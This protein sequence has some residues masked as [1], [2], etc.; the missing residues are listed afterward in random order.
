M[1][2][3]TDRYELDGLDEEQRRAVTHG[4]GPLLVMAGPGSGKTRVLTNRV[5]HLIGEGAKP[6]EILCLTFTEKAAAEMLGRLGRRFD[7]SNMDVCTFHAFAKKM[8]GENDLETGLNVSRG[9]I[10]R[11]MARA[12]AMGHIDEF[13][14]KSVEIGNNALRVIGAIMEGISALRKETVSTDDL[15]EY[16]EERRGK[17]KDAEEKD[18]LAKLEDL[19]RVYRMY[20]E[21]KRSMAVIDFDDMINE[22][23]R[24]LEGRPA[25]L[26]RYRRIYKHVLVDELQDNNYAQFKLVKMLAG[27]G[28]VTA[29][30]DPD[31]SIYRFQ[32]AYTDIFGDFERSFAGTARVGLA[33]NYRSTPNI[34]GLTGGW[35]RK[36]GGWKGRSEAE[37]AREGSGS[38]GAITVA[39]CGD[40]RAEAEYVAGKIA[41]I[42]GEEEGE[43]RLRYKDVAILSRRRIDGE[44][45]E[46]ALRERGIPARYSGSTDLLYA[47][48][49]RD[50]LAYLKIAR[51]PAGAGAEI[52]QIMSRH[53]I[54][55]RNISRINRAAK[56]RRYGGGPGGGDCVYETVCTRGAVETTQE[57]ELGELARKLERLRE[58][59][60][61]AESVGMVVYETMMSV[62]GLYGE[63]ARKA[64]EA[65]TETD[66]G[67]R[68]RQLNE[69]YRIATEYEK[70]YRDSRL[71]DFI[72]HLYHAGEIDDEGREPDPA[73][74]AV[75]ITT[76]HQSKGREFGAV[77]VADVADRRLPVWYKKK[78]FHVPPELVRR[79]EQYGD[80]KE[81]HRE[82]ERRLLY[83]AMTRAKDI[84]YMTRAK[85]HGAG[86]TEAKPSPYLIE[87]RYED[88]PLIRVEDVGRTGAEEG[89]ALG[90]GEVGKFGAIRRELQGRAADA[91]TRMDL[92][93]AV[94]AIVDLSEVAH[95]EK[96]GSLDGLDPAA[97]LDVGGPSEDLGSRLAG[98]A[99]APL[100]DGRAVAFS[101]SKIELYGRCPLQFKFRYVLHAPSAPAAPASVGTAVH[102]VLEKAAR[103]RMRGEEAGEKEALE[104]LDANW[105]PEAFQSTTESR[106][107]KDKAAEMIRK[108]VGW[109]TGRA[110]KVID[111]ERKFG[112]DLDGMRFEGKM[113]RMEE[114]PDGG[115]EVVDY[116]TGKPKARLSADDVQMNLYALAIESDRGK[117]PK[118][119]SHLYV[120]TCAQPHNDLDAGSVR[121]EEAAI[122]EKARAIR[123]GEFGATPE[124]G[125]CTTCDYKGICEKKYRGA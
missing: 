114:D 97:V 10:N 46:D 58:I 71:G 107:Y 32:G 86:E 4:G 91:V 123:N 43:G 119:V 28:N 81:Q 50:L 14:L 100:F 65:E 38:G 75:E 101:A 93:A 25:V 31:Q 48:A 55:E 33:R 87:M 109:D 27:A 63:A 37:S 53:G 26:E 116:K 36:A 115:I 88:S 89:P 2:A 69:V 99:P 5:L 60:G 54:S 1:G 102:T 42:A 51:D 74:N 23:I 106:E 82:E 57:A 96:K 17:E 78:K 90:R 40:E 3:G 45:F 80:E 104:L 47:P 98:A 13:G 19:N 8:L 73:E 20:Q 70:I 52:T 16:I 83:V 84:L 41:E 29:V 122:L 6:E 76:I 113:D 59:G 22:A 111:V 85:R 125:K 21:H 92:S 120:K 112:F 11:P 12:W 105:E 66:G 68:L 72:D 79:G 7:A 61:G 44:K 94:R 15:A 117:I 103:R 35:M 77:F 121:K 30:G 9:V 49:V 124:Y 110:N 24:L 64:A 108:Y 62:S 118:R 67:K 39:E 34:V 56:N 95:F 18:T